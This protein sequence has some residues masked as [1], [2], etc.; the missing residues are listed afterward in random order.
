MSSIF[1]KN[2]IKNRSIFQISLRNF[3]LRKFKSITVS[4]KNGE[5]SKQGDNG[6]QL[7]IKQPLQDL[8]ACLGTCEIHSVHFCAKQSQVPIEKMEVNCQAEYD[9]DLFMGKKEGRNTYSSIDIEV[10]VSSS[11]KNREKLDQ[12][13]KKGMELCPIY[14]TLSYAGIRINKTTKYL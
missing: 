4:D 9:V 12:T 7:S 13:V 2:F 10:I 11:E 3:S 1:T 8:L 6:S 5:I 14:N